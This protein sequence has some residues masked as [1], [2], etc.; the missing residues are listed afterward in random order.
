MIKILALHFV[1]LFVNK[2]NNFVESWG[3]RKKDNI[4]NRN[5]NT[6]KKFASITPCSI[7]NICS[8]IKY[9]YIIYL[10]STLE[11]ILKA[12]TA[13]A[14]GDKIYRPLGPCSH[15]WNWSKTFAHRIFIIQSFGAVSWVEPCDGIKY[16]SLNY[17]LS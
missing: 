6:R 9:M 11:F 15:L 16:S 2:F 5:P 4:Q 14:A 8:I 12:D 3:G 13:A 7:A 10:R 1:W 17:S